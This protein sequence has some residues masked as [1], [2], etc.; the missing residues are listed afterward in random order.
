MVISMPRALGVT[1][2]PETYVVDKHQTI[3]FH[4]AGP[5]TRDIINNDILPLVK[6]LNNEK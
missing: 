4:H 6:K 1:G 2:V 3:V 5:L